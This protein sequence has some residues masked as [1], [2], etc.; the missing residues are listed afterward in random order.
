MIEKY[1]TKTIFRYSSKWIVLGIDLFV[2]G[3]AFM[4]SY[5]IRFN[6]TINFDVNKLFVQL[7]FV[8]VTAFLSFLITGSYK[9]V[10][11]HTGG[12]VV[13]N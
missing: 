4:L 5:F 11:R 2:V 12:K 13:Y 9:G 3:I 8:L 10:V 7:P 1:L 6:L